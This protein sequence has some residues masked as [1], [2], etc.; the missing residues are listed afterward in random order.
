M[1]NVNQGLNGESPRANV[2]L[3]DGRNGSGQRLISE[4]QSTTSGAGRQLADDNGRFV[5]TVA[6]GTLRKRISGSKHIL[7]KLN[8]IA[9]DVRILEEAQAAGAAR[10]EVTDRENGNCYTA[11][12][13]DFWARGVRINFDTPQLALPL[14]RWHIERP[15]EPRQLALFG[16]GA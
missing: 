13:G 5:A 1:Q 15:G 8:A 16:A 12:L 14:P 3:L 11:A 9:F 7:K 10:V 4:K 6:R 2:G